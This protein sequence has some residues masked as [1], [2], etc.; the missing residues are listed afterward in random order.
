LVAQA[1]SLRTAPADTGATKNF[2]MQSR[3]GLRRTRKFYEM[4]KMSLPP[5]LNL[6]L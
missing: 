2:S 6:E 4:F 1:S 3:M 5:T